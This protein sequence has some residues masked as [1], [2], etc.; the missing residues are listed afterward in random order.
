[1]Q[2]YRHQLAQQGYGIKVGKTRVREDH[3]NKCVGGL[4]LDEVCCVNGVIAE[5]FIGSVGR[6]KARNL[7]L[8][9]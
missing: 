4:V 2:F 5:F 6:K 8:A 7:K 1:M 3:E 9:S